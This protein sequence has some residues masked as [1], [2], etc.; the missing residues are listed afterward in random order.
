MRRVPK[1]LLLL[2][3][4]SLALAVAPAGA[5]GG[6][7]TVDKVGWWYRVQG[8][9]KESPAPPPGGVV[10]AIPQPTTGV[11]EGAIAV[12]ARLGEDD[13][14]AAIGM[15]LD[16][17]P[18]ATVERFTLTLQ[19]AE[20][21][22]ANQN[23]GSAAIRAC[24]VVSF[25]AGVENGEWDT[26]P[27][28][29]CD[30]ASS[31]GV[32]N[33]DG[34]WTFD[35]RAIGSVLL[36]PFGMVA[37]NGILLIPAVEPPQTFQVSFATGEAI[38]IDF[39][40]SGGTDPGSAFDLDGGFDDPGFDGGGDPGFDGGGSDFD[41]GGGTGFDGGD[42]DPG[43]APAPEAPD[44]GAEPDGPAA[45]GSDGIEATAAPATGTRAGHTLGNLP[46]SAVLAV[47]GLIALLVAVSYTLGPAGRPLPAAVR[48]Q[49]GVSRALA[50]RRS[51]TPRTPVEVSS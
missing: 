39:A 22:G 50:A 16:A 34:S 48:R 31:D 49:G 51:V 1:G 9:Q 8:A 38:T 41:A 23:A 40:A 20:C 5:Q 19:E 33:D 21:A 12:A 18:G 6:G 15:L 4:C 32:R 42:F 46:V 24:P 45:A 2:V 13:K 10:P 11:P 26:R 28:A 29:D 3:A 7:V 14:V 36:D 35:L 37:E 17:N 44:A 30:S 27:E 43:P 25:W 47:V